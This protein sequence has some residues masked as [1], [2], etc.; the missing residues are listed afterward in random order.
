MD[1]TATRTV[2]ISVQKTVHREIEG[3]LATDVSFKAGGHGH[4]LHDTDEHSSS[5]VQSQSDRGKGFLASM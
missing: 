1:P 2:E 3:E 5:D 4:A